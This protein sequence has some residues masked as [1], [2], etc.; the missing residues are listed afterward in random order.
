MSDWL[1]VEQWNRQRK[2]TEA[3]RQPT[4]QPAPKRK[5]KRDWFS[6]ALVALAII[7]LLFA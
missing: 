1:T 4:W 7:S 3:L 6:W 2:R 5:Q